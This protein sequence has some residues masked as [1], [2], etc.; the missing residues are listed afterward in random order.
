MTPNFWLLVLPGAM[1]IALG[2]HQIVF[3]AE[4]QERMD[5]RNLKWSFGSRYDRGWWQG[6]RGIG[7]FNIFVGVT[8]MLMQLGDRRPVDP[9]LLRWMGGLLIA[10]GLWSLVLEPHVSAWWWQLRRRPAGNRGPAPYSHG[11]RSGGSEVSGPGRST[12][13]RHWHGAMALFFGAS[14]LI[15]AS[16]T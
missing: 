8:W 4:V 9:T 3:A 11:E 7:I 5:E 2:V 1:W 14:T 13:A 12:A 6:A 15:L 16:T 10:I